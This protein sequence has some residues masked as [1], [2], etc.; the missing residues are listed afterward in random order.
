MEEEKKFKSK[1]EW[2]E[3]INRLSPKEF[4]DLCYDLLNNNNFTN[5]KPRGNGADGGRD[6]EGDFSYSMGKEKIT[7][8]CWVQCK[9]YGTTPLN[10]GS[11]DTEAQKADD[12]GIEQFII[13]SNKDLADRG[14]TDVENWN[15]KHKCQIRDWTGTLFLNILFGEPN[16]CRT[17][18]P[19]DEVPMVVDAK[20][21][22]SAIQL[23]KNVGNRFGIEIELNVKDINLNNPLEIA[24]VLKEALLKLE[25]DINL[26][27]LI[28]EK[29]SMFFFSLGQTDDAIAF[30][31]KSLDITPKNASALLNKGYILEKIDKLDESNSVYDELFTIDEKNVLALNNKAFNLLRQGELEKALELI[32][33]ALELNPKLIIAIKNKI[34]ILKG[35]K[36]IDEAL[37]FLSKNEDSFEKS[38]D[39][40]TEKVDLCIEKIDLREAFRINEEIL[41]KEPEN[42]SALNN[43]GVI[44]ERNSKHQLPQKYVPLAL[45]AFEQL[46]Q[47]NSN[48][49]LGWSN[50][51]AMLVKIGNLLEA[52]KIIDEAYS[53]FPDVSEV[54]NKKGVL[55][56]NQKQERKAIKYFDSALKKLYRGEY[57]LNRAKANLKIGQQER[58]LRDL[59]RLLSYEKENSEAWGLKGVIL[60][61]LRRPFW[62]QAFQNAEKFKETPI[63]LL[64]GDAQNEERRA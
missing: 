34:R 28:Y 15:K 57:L 13:I 58:T 64:E 37:E 39:L 27:A 17:Y 38:T 18:F 19:D 44:Y 33:R 8:K 21:P 50:K 35:L 52:E 32:N 41:K 42:L 30:L 55:L 9:R 11:F 16:I 29:I 2:K 31:N 20:N 6:L 47:K 40:M 3:L 63:S 7:H 45:E 1:D 24:K 46:I 36:R 14:K 10:F 53:L 61:R 48:F 5:L 25:G 26:K 4:Q 59:E 23:S 22:Q 60:R 62:Q 43:K 54:L 12:Q 49:A 56:L 51:T